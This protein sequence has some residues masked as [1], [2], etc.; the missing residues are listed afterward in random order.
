MAQKEKGGPLCISQII[1][2]RL[3]GQKPWANSLRMQY[4]NHRNSASLTILVRALQSPRQRE[5]VELP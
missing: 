1:L 5:C 4:A 2:D 3:L